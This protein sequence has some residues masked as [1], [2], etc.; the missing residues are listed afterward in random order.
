MCEVNENA[1]AVAFAN[2]LLAN[3]RQALMLRRTGLEITECIACVMNA[4][5]FNAAGII[6]DEARPFDGQHDV[7]CAAQRQIDVGGFVQDRE[8]LL[9][10]MRFD[11]VEFAPEPT[12]CFA[13]AGG[14]FLLEGFCV[15]PKEVA[16]KRPRDPSC[17]SSCQ[18][19]RPGAQMVFA[20]TE[21]RV[22]VHI[23]D[24]G[25]YLRPGVVNKRQRAADGGSNEF[26]TVQHT[27]SPG[28]ARPRS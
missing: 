24:K 7:G 21:K 26:T 17:A 14:R 18:S 8:S 27:P 6:F 5:D 15:K 3:L 23:T 4:G 12:Q 28:K 2:D 20:P 16:D 22:S 9:R 1:K 25:R 13:P 19:R 11:T 10:N